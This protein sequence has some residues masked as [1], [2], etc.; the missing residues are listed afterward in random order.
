[1][2][3]VWAF[4][5]LGSWFSADG[6]HL[7]DVKTKVARATKTAGKMRNIWASKY[8]PLQLKSCASIKRG[9]ARSWRTVRR[10]GF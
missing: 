6:N 1:M 2:E 3:N 10:R 4:K 7:T 5:Y 9:F 8:V